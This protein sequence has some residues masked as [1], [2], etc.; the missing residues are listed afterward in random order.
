MKETNRAENAAPRRTTRHRKK[1]NNGKMLYVGILVL[2]MAILVFSSIK[3][4]S[5]L[6]QQKMSENL[7]EDIISDFVSPVHDENIDGDGN[8]IVAIGPGNSNNE[9]EP[10]HIDVNF[11]KLL[12]QY[13][14]TV[15]FIYGAN[16][17]ICYPIVQGDD[18][19]FYLTHNYD[20][21]TDNNGSIFMEYLCAPDFTSQNTII[22]GHHMKSGRMFANLSKYKNQSYYDAHPYMYIY[23]P[24]KEY[25]LEFFA[26][27]VVEGSD[28]IYAL[29]VSKD[30]LEQYV[31]ES[32]FKSKIG[33]P[34]GNIVTLSTCDYT[35][36]YDDARYIVLGKLTELK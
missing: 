24:E 16:T 27:C 3:I 20:G 11:K 23:T 1:K 28:P 18:N 19:D 5:Y 12:K 25:K 34:E 36:G 4:I 31:A 26:G 2:L 6:S 21:N 22:Y 9:P 13:P 15:G 32:T 35:V 7:Q 14:D 17:G 33:V 8:G 10:E 30:V 29:E